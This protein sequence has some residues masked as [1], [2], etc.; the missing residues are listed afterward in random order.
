[1]L[2]TEPGEA[3]LVALSDLFVGARRE[4]EISAR[5]EPLTR[6]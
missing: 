6:E 4:D 3:E 5:R 2:L 1:M